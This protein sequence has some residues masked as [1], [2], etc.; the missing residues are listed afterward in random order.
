MEGVGRGR[1]SRSLIPFTEA[2][3]FTACAAA[4]CCSDLHLT[5]TGCRRGGDLLPGNKHIGGK[6]NVAVKINHR[7]YIHIL[8]VNDR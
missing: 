3:T 8:F 6:S 2:D 7:K 1:G 4:R 5:F